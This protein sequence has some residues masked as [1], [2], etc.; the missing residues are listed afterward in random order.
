MADIDDY[1]DELDI[2]NLDLQ[3]NDEP[4]DKDYIPPIIDSEILYKIEEPNIPANDID[5]MNPIDIEVNYKIL[6]R[7]GHGAFGVVYKVQDIYTKKVYALKMM[8]P[9]Q[10]KDIDEVIS[11]FK[12]LKSLGDL[13]TQG[14]V[15]YYKL[16]LGLYRDHQR[17]LVK[18]YCLLMDYVQGYDLFDYIEGEC[19]DKHKQ[20]NWLSVDKILVFMKHLTGT[21]KLLHDNDIVH[22]DIKAE[23]VIYGKHKMVL[24]DYGFMCYLSSRKNMKDELKSQCKDDKGTPMYLSPEL[25]DVYLNK[26]KLTDAKLKAGDVWALGVLFY[27]FINCDFPFAGKDPQQIGQKQFH[28]FLKKGMY[29]IS[30]KPNGPISKIVTLMLHPNYEKR[31]NIT[32]VYE[33]LQSIE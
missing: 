23:N 20:N 24:I 1:F 32:Q 2:T 6:K 25:Y 19:V 8:H 21:L 9:K 33:M 11:E 29:N 4:I 14:L 16:F 30:F 31:P 28:T 10:I 26:E 18:Y 17:K 5:L 27:F 7:L 3:D 13:C 15:C 12:I 22:R